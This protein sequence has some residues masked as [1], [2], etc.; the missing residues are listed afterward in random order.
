MPASAMEAPMSRIKFRRLG[1]SDS[2][3][4]TE[5][6]NPRS[7][8]SRNAPVRASSSRPRQTASPGRAATRFRACA[9]SEGFAVRF[10]AASTVARV[11]ILKLL[12]GQ[13]VIFRNQPY[14]ERFLRFVGMIGVVRG[15]VIHVEDLL[16]RADEVLWPAVTIE[17]PGHLQRAGLE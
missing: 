7:T 14:A 11:T 2:R 12:A 10:I 3:S 16:A 6:G 5:A 17:A 9:R 13:H 15:V 4:I 1:P 8:A